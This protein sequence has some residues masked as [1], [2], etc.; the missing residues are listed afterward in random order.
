MLVVAITNSLIWLLL[1]LI[2]DPSAITNF[3]FTLCWTGLLL[4]AMYKLWVSVAICAMRGESV[5]IHPDHLKLAKAGIVTC[6]FFLVF[7]LLIVLIFH[8]TEEPTYFYCWSFWT[9]PM[10]LGY[11]CIMLTMACTV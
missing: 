1:V 10:Y 2:E 9:V 6:V 3:G 7:E 11:Y 5:R 4:F 8:F